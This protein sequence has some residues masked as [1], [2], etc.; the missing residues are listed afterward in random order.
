MLNIGKNLTFVSKKHQKWSKSH[1]FLMFFN[2]Y[3]LNFSNK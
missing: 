1:K 2:K 3:A